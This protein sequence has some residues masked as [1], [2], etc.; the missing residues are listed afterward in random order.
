MAEYRDA[1]LSVRF[2]ELDAETDRVESYSID[3]GY[4]TPTDGF[5]VKIYD[6]DVAKVRGLEMQPVDI[7]VDNNVQLQGRVDQTVITDKAVTCNG[8]DYI[9]DITECNVDPTLKIKEGDTLSDAL[10]LGLGPVGIDTILSDADF[11][12]RDI[13]TGRRIGAP[14]LADF[15]QGKLEDY[16]AN[17][18]EGLFEFYNRIVARFGCTIQPGSDRNTIYLTAPNYGQEPSYEIIVSDGD[19]S[20]RSSNNVLTATATRGFASFPTYALFN[21]WK[22]NKGGERV[23]V[24]IETDILDLAAT[25]SEEL[26]Q[27][28]N[29]QVQAGRIKPGTTRPGSK[30]Y[31]LLY[32]R[33]DDSRSQEQLEKSALRA[34]AERLKDSLIY[35]CTVQGHRD[36]RTDILWA[37][38]TIANVNDDIRDVHEPMWIARRTFRFDR[39]SG[40]VTDLTMWR[41]GVF[42]I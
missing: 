28:L 37:T 17:P 41:K 19:D 26:A 4:L 8:R 24:A 34:I 16:K 12:L 6:E 29:A 32:Y 11:A 31:R 30:L 22:T 3:S 33:D 2:P 42:I 10:L 9:A 7:L 35:T 15:R 13:R 23:P 27:T 5:T 20:L 21:G 25:F 40:A 39:G 1:V 36:P 38:D 14:P 18:G